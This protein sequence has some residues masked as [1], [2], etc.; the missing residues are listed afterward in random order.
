M[1]P[2]YEECLKKITAKEIKYHIYKQFEENPGQKKYDLRKIAHKVKEEFVVSVDWNRE[3]VITKVKEI[4]KEYVAEME[5]DPWAW[6]AK[7]TPIHNET[8]YDTPYDIALRAIGAQE[9]DAKLIREA[10]K[11]RLEDGE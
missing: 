10:L 11:R 5:K 1:L 4:L 9:E 8:T 6:Q 7:F 2:S 3:A